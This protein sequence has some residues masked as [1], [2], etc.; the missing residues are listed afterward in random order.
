MKSEIVWRFTNNRELTATEFVDYFERKVFKT[1]RKYNLLPRNRIVKLGRDG[2]LN[3]AVLKHILEKKFK[4]K[5]VSKSGFSKG[6]LSERAEEVF[7]NV[8]AGKFDSRRG[9]VGALG[10]LSDAE[11]ELY[12]QLVGVRGK[13]RKR[14]K[15]VQ[16]LFCKFVKK[17]PDLEHNVVGA[18]NLL[19][20]D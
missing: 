5:F 17:N 20:V 9:Q 3:V 16:E 6:G 15:K 2:S 14:D 8:L 19:H 10:L 11:I 12:A 18:S 7:K 13:K 4:V 1:I